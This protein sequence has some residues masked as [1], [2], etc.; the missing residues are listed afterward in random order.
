MSWDAS[1]TIEVDGN[2]VSLFETNYTHN[3]N[4][5]INEALSNPDVSTYWAPEFGGCWWEVFHNKSAKDTLPLLET[6][7][8]E[9]ENKPA[10]YKQY[11]APN[12]WGTVGG[13]LERFKDMKEVA[14]KFP[15][16]TWKIYG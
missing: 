3:I 5:A 2:E 1:L 16:A 11:D 14:E 10:E 9:F 15:S 12:G 4:I 7:I 6:I 13:V 8:W